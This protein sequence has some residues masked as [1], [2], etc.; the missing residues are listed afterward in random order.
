MS[1]FNRAYARG[2]AETLMREGH[3][4]VASIEIA[5]Q[6]ADYVGDHILF[7]PTQKVARDHATE[8][9]TAILKVAM[10]E[11]ALIT[12]DK[13]EQQ[14]DPENAAAQVGGLGALD[15]K[16]RPEGTYVLGQGQTAMDA[17]MLG[18]EVV[19]PAAP[20][21]KGETATNSVNKAAALRSILNKIAAGEGPLITGDKPEQQNTP[22]NA[23]A[24]VGGLAALDQKDRPEG[25]Y[26]KG[27]AKTDLGVPASAQIGEEK[28]HPNAPANKGETASNSVIEAIKGA[29]AK[30]LY[31]Q[32]FEA[33]A[34]KVASHLPQTMSN[35]EKVA[36]IKKMM[37]M[38]DE[39]QVTFL[40]SVK[41]SAD[42]D[43]HKE[44]VEAMMPKKKDD[45]KKEEKKDD[46]KK[47]E[48]TAAL[49]VSNLLTEIAT[50]ANLAARQ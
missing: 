15:Q 6:I 33:T 34:K 35:N 26:H 20:A 9:A 18:K 24:Q 3:L 42:C 25:E 7:D 12:G 1:I 50:L 49:N 5:E 39:E 13:P 16:D 44:L 14:N 10:D 19:Q 29:N 22:E 41:T 36:S 46:E 28:A 40:T 30:D 47:E 11:G 23:A 37:G 32:L 4:K 48:K 45:E 43:D 17:P 2:I 31:V 8:V 38:S 21:N 27:M